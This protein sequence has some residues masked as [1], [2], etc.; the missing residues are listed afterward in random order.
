MTGRLGRPALAVPTFAAQ[1]GG[2]AYVA[3]LVRAA[4]SDFVGTHPW[5]LELTPT[6]RAMTARDVAGFGLRLLGAN[7]ARQADWVYF[8]HP[9]I[10]RAQR[11]IPRPF[12]LPYT[13][14]L[15]GTEAWE[16]QLPQSVW[17]ADLRIAPS[18]FTAERCRMA[19]PSIG[20]IV[21]CPHGLLP[22]EPATAPPDWSLL[23]R[24]R[25][26]S[27]V[28]VGRLHPDER[29]K[30]HDQLI[31]CWPM[32]RAAVPQAQLII[33]GA[34]GDLPR[35]REKARAVADD[36]TILFAGYVSPAT[37]T[38]LFRKVAMLAMPSRQEGFGI[39][40]L[41]AMKAALPCIAATDDGASE[42]I[43][44]GETGLLVEQSNLSEL[45]GAIVSLLESEEYRRRLGANGQRRYL[46]EFTFEAYKARLADIL[47]SAFGR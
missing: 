3:R 43:V 34:G 5:S 17:E 9:G 15:H 40:Y 37:L 6:A 41:E 28:I 33:A 29:R 21:V 10:S 8:A 18:R 13:V 44:S 1:G 36:E 46:A 47:Q 16:G 4:L 26:C 31:E 7:V 45:A 32:V 30:G 11:A 12:R 24:V 19:H 35:L 23:S 42:P 25:W 22:E 14:Q 20:P 27:A 2:V 38:A 39:V